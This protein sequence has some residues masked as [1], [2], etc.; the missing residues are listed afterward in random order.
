MYNIM[1][2]KII[3]SFDIP[4]D[5]ASFRVKIWR[6]L[7]KL[8]AHRELRSFWTLDMSDENIKKLKSLAK[9]IADNRG[10]AEI[11]EGRIIWKA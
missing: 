7:K 11:I 4:R 5:K 10:I 9:E 2:N 6:E 1:Q 8:N 3:F